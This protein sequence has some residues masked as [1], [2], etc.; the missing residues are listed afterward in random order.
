MVFLENNNQKN[1][2]PLT[3][4]LKDFLYSYI[5]DIYAVAQIVCSNELNFV[6]Q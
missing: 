2:L 4:N 3:N 6:V 5:Q 1:N